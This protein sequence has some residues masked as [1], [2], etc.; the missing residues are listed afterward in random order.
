[1]RSTYDPGSGTEGRQKKKERK[2]KERGGGRRGRDKTTYLRSAQIRADAITCSRSWSQLYAAP[3][4]TR[5]RTDRCP[6]A[7]RNY[8]KRGKERHR[9]R[10]GPEERERERGRWRKKH[11]CGALRADGWPHERECILTNAFTR[12]RRGARASERA[13]H[14]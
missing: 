6:S 13:A 7:G 12:A 5:S 10:E 9:G 11:A 4:R 14:V 3:R 2:T 8:I 1:M